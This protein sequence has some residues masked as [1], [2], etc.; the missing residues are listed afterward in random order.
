MQPIEIAQQFL[1]FRRDGRLA[2]KIVEIFL[3]GEG[4][5]RT[6]HMTAD[7]RIG[8]MKN[9][10]RAHDRLGSQEQIFDLKQIAIAQHGLQRR[11]VGVCAQHED[12]VEPRLFGEFA[13]VDFKRPVAFVFVLAFGLVLGPG[14]LA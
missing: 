8:R 3:H 10:P 13:G 12:A 14:A 1:P 7:R 4:Q 6:E 2:G 5:E 9:R 11:H